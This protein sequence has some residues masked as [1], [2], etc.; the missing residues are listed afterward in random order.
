MI[1]LDNFQEL[2]SIGVTITGNKDDEFILQ[3]Y[4]KLKIQRENVMLVVREYNHLQLIMSP[5]EKYLFRD[6]IEKIQQ[7]INRGVKIL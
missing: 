2:Q 7:T 5:F 3:S 4:H 6:Y 1:E